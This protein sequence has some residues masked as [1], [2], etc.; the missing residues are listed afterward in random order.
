MGMTNTA[1]PRNH[2]STSSAA[3]CALSPVRAVEIGLVES[4]N[5]AAERVESW[6][7]APAAFLMPMNAF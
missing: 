1:R 7:R 2:G 6:F 5:G 3:P 4:A